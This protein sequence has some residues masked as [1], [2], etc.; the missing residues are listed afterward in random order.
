MGPPELPNYNEI[1][2]S[3]EHEEVIK[4]EINEK[5]PQDGQETIPKELAL[6]IVFDLSQKEVSEE[7][8]NKIF[9]DGEK[10]LENLTRD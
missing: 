6:Q 8:Y 2:L 3:P 5:W 7:V 10:P 1:A 4:L 9:N